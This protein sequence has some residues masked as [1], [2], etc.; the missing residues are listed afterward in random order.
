MRRVGFKGLRSKVEELKPHRV[1]L[2]F[3]LNFQF[4]IDFIASAYYKL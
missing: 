1:S 4:S 2:I 3:N